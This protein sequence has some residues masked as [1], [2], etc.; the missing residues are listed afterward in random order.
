MTDTSLTLPARSAPTRSAA[1][2][3]AAEETP[4]LRWGAR[5]SISAPILA[6]FATVAG[7]PLYADEMSEA[8]ATGRFTV[9]AAGTLAALIALVAAL[10][11]L[12]L[13]QHRRLHALGHAGLLIG[14]AGTVLAA[15]GAWDSLFTVPYLAEQAPAVLDVDTSGSLLAGFVISYLA[16]VLGWVLFAVATLR[17]RVLPRSGSIVMLVGAILAF[18]PAPT[19]LRILPL[20]VGVA[21]CARGVLRGTAA[22]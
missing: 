20:A 6:L 4:L 2:A 9:A 17:A 8:G 12:Y 5:A 10:V 14:F 18:F 19:S 11:G 7:A 13:A 15:G 3:A 21:L 16:L 22:R 1:V